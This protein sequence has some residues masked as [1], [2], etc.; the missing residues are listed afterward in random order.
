M[1]ALLK[2][3]VGVPRPGPEARSRTR[4]A[5]G[6]TPATPPSPG[7]SG[8]SLGRIAPRTALGPPSGEECLSSGLLRFA[9]NDG[10]LPAMTR[11]RCHCESAAT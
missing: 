1:D 2:H 6:Q 3:T 7:P 4:R 8:A 9:R 11:G 10:G 5:V